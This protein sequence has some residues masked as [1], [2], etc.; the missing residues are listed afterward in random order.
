MADDSLHNAT[1]FSEMQH[2]LQAQAARP[3]PGNQAR[4]LPLAA[5]AGWQAEAACALVSLYHWI[6][7]QLAQTLHLTKAKLNAVY[8]ELPLSTT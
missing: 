6:F 7:S 2:P 1:L 3:V 8:S 5:A 4:L